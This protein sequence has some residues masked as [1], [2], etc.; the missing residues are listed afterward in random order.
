MCMYMCVC[1][2]VCGVCVFVRGLEGCVWW[3]VWWERVQLASHDTN[4]L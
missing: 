2:S 1:M 4:V 3:D